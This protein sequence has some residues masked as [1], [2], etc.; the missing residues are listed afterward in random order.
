MGG[1]ARR[2]TK[3]NEVRDQGISVVVLEGGGFTGPEDELGELKFETL[4]V[5]F[6]Q[7]RYDAI[8]IGISEI[9]MLTDGHGA[10]EKLRSSRLPLSTLNL[11]YNGLLLADKPLIIQRDEIKVAVFSLFLEEKIPEGPAKYWQVIDPEQVITDALQYARKNS[12]FIIALLYGTK[13]EVEQ[14]VA[15]HRGMDIV[16]DAMNRQPAFRPL[17]VNTS[18][19]LSAGEGGKYLGKID[20]QHGDAG[21]AFEARLVALTKSVAEDERLKDTYYAYLKRIRELMREQEEDLVKLSQTGLPPM[22][23][24][25]DCSGCHE[26]IYNKWKE[27]R[28]ARAMLSLIYK[29]EDYNPECLPCHAVAY[30]EGGFISLARTP[31]YAGVQ[32]V[33]C[34]GNMQDHMEY[35][36][37]LLDEE[38]FRP[39][40]VTEAICLYCHTDQRDDDFVY[41]RD[42]K[43]VHND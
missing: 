22:P 1:M 28:H 5:A 34:H 17:T 43:Q 35:H 27:T 36:D 26:E 31:E 13:T 32:C 24:A 40:E 3:I 18:L 15:R 10:W 25:E 21:W 11:S 30:R 9:L 2:A 38:T 41:A 23:I 19:I 37:G 29:K 39:Q 14:F 33:S 6:Q 20:A 42:K 7:M 16:I 12:D 4:L 8:G